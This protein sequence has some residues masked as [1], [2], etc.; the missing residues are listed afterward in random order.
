MKNYLVPAAAFGIAVSLVW[1]GGKLLKMTNVPKPYTVSGL[2][3][4]AI[5]AGMYRSISESSQE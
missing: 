5:W 3:V 2:A 1:G 4:S